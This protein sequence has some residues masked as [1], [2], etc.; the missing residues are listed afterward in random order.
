MPRLPAWPL[1]LLIKLLNKQLY[2]SIRLLE[3]HAD[4]K[5]HA[6]GKEFVWKKDQRLKSGENYTIVFTCTL[7]GFGMLITMADSESA[8]RQLPWWIQRV[9]HGN[10]HDG[11]RESGA[12]ITITDSE[13]PT[14]QL[15]WLPWQIQTESP[16][17]HLPRQIQRIRHANY[18]GRFSE[19]CTVITTTD[20]ESP[21]Q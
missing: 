3:L 17:Q 15:D 11:F 5:S 2:L 12:V 20:S 18:H 4:E 14:E 19:S 13:R 10:Y 21:T 9:R 1:Q 8:A 6:I 16:T 7:R